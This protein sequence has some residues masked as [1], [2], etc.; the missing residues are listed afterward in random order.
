M[1]R[2]LLFLILIFM[3]FS[4]LA[5]WS[6]ELRYHKDIA[7]TETPEK[8][9]LRQQLVEILDRLAVYQHYYKANYGKFTKIIHRLG[10]QIPAEIRTFYDFRVSE[11]TA[12][13][14]Q[15][16]AVSE[17]APKDPQ[18]QVEIAS[19]NEG[20]RFQ[21][22]FEM[23]EPRVEYLKAYAKKNL[24]NLLITRKPVKEAAIYSGY[25]KYDIKKDS[26]MND[27]AVATGI[28]YP[29]AN[30][31][32][33]FAQ[34]DAGRIPN[35]AP[36]NFELSGRPKDEVELAL[37]IFR[38]ET[39]RVAQNWF[40]LE[41]VSKPQLLELLEVSQHNLPGEL[42]KLK[43]I[44]FAERK[45]SSVLEK[46]TELQ[47]S[48]QGNDMASDLVIEPLYPESGKGRGGRLTK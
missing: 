17:D 3:S 18:R 34:I 22:N 26:D 23:P 13:T 25:F 6:N 42:E 38:G 14:F 12:N 44:D 37:I 4:G 29:V 46:E 16:I 11:A 21:S 31:Q 28:K 1:V 39:G 47:P 10:L 20:F 15:I 2:R 40:E 24:R 36:I 19:V 30:S 7:L 41:Q 5:W 48:R 35:D 45:V 9:E 33:S 8:S 27:V 43:E 32:V